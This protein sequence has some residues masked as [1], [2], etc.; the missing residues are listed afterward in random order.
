MPYRWIQRRLRWPKVK[1]N[2]KGDCCAMSDDLAAPTSL[3]TEF[4]NFIDR[5][6]RIALCRPDYAWDYFM[7]VKA[8]RAGLDPASIDLDSP[9]C[10]CFDYQCAQLYRTYKNSRHNLTIQQ[11]WA[12]DLALV[13]MLP[14]EALKAKAMSVRTAYCKLAGKRM[15]EQYRLSAPASVDKLT[16]DQLRAEIS[17]LT[18]GK[19]WYQLN[20]I[21]LERG[22]RSL[23]KMVLGWAYKGFF[24][25][26]LII[27]GLHLWTSETQA[28][29]AWRNAIITICLTAYFGILGAVISISRRTKAFNRIAESDSDPII[30]LGRME[31]GKTGMHLSIVAGGVFAIVLYLIFVAGLGKLVLVPELLPTFAFRDAKGEFAYFRAL[32]P[33]TAGDLAKLLLWAFIAGFA[34]K[35]VPDVLDRFARIKTHDDDDDDKD[36]LVNTT[37]MDAPS[38]TRQLRSRRARKQKNLLGLK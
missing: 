21:L 8:E 22:F 31:N 24:V 16:V 20:A 23:K 3:K 6:T 38:A 18:R 30:R 34:E 10:I 32:T 4:W 33:G 25:M 13:Q 36:V 14:A 37:V 35:L 12:V 2:I 19:Y 5:W 9:A 28:H 7:L 27:C 17:D 11:V 26:L 15:Y 29:I 1:A